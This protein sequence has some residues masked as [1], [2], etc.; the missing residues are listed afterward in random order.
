MPDPDT[1]AGWPVVTVEIS[2]DGAVVDGAPVGVPSGMAARDAAI[3][4]VADIARRVGRTVRVEAIEEDGTV[5]PLFVSPTGAVT[6][7]GSA[8][9]RRTRKEPRKLGPGVPVPTARQSASL[10][11]IRAALAGD[12]PELALDLAR[13]F[14]RETASHGDAAA[15]LAAREVHAYTALRAGSTEQAVELFAQAAVARA[16]QEE[17]VEATVLTPD[18]WAWRLVQNAHYCWLQV[19]DVEDA[20]G[21]SPYVLGAYSAVGAPEADAA[22]AARAHQADLRRQLLAG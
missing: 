13:A 1:I 18:R 11:S 14:A 3:G 20:Y 22:Q 2:A 6:E 8:I 16:A 5:H 10:H 19:E 7:A 9:P 21:L 17:A 15:T 12:D 4:T